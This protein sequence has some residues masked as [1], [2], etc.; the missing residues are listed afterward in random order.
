MYIFSIEF[1]NKFNIYSKVKKLTT[2][3]FTTLNI[4]Y[5]KKILSPKQL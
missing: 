3:K 2:I 5:N 4:F 1:T